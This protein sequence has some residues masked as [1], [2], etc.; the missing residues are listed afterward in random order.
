MTS[1]NELKTSYRHEVKE[2]VLECLRFLIEFE[3]DDYN[4]FCGED[5]FDEGQHIYA[6][7]KR[8]YEAITNE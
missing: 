7:A 3:E 4:R 1:L 2:D 8:A 6:V 5:D